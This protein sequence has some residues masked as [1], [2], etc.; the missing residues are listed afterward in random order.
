MRAVPLFGMKTLLIA[1]SIFLMA[2]AGYAQT[3]T[4]ERVM[5]GHTL[6]LTSGEEVRLIGL[7]IPGDEKAGPAAEFVQG[8]G[9]EGQEVRLEFDVQER[10][11]DGRVLAY[12][13]APV[14]SRMVNS[15][16]VAD[17]SCRIPETKIFMK[18]YKDCEANLNATIIKAGYASP[19]AAPPNVKYADLF[20]RLHQEAREQKRGLWAR[21]KEPGTES[22]F[23]DFVNVPLSKP[24]KPK[25]LLRY[26]DR[27]GV[28]LDTSF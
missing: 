17:E 18:A 10:D 13:Y 7:E 9:L 14:H 19:M 16:V 2:P 27:S 4:V 5:D 12:V 1:L 28:K 24:Q 21:E 8:L 20:K 25:G 26:I 15:I 6:K 22:I 11:K 3:Y 23:K